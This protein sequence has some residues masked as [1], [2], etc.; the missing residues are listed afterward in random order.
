MSLRMGLAT[1]SGSATADLSP[2]PAAVSPQSIARNVLWSFSGNVLLAFCQWAIVVVLARLGTPHTVGVFALALAVA[3]PVILLASLSL[4]TYQVTDTGCDYA[5]SEYITIRV[6]AMAL[7][8]MAIGGIAFAVYGVDVAWVIVLVGVAKALDAVSDICQGALQQAERLDLMARSMILSGVLSLAGLTAG[9]LATGRLHWGVMGM[10]AASALTLG[11]YNLPQAWS[12]VRQR[13]SASLGKSSAWRPR[14]LTWLAWSALPLTLAHTLTALNANVPRYYIE[15]YL[16]EAELGVFA[17][18]SYCVM[19]GQ[20]VLSAVAQTLL[21]RLSAL[22]AAGDFS[23]YRRLLSKSLLAVTVGGAALVVAAAVFG[24]PVLRVIYGAAY[25]T[26]MDVFLWLTLG[27][28]ISFPVWLVDAAISSA[29]RFRVQFPI[30]AVSLASSAVACG[31]WI[32]RYGLVGAAW[33][34]CLA[35]SMMLVLK[36]LVLIQVLRADESR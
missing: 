26:R 2:G 7:A 23:G 21:P 11:S 35:L 12:I 22:R 18:L 31:M 36:T 28:A 8:I 10:I 4:R 33:S 29:R 34:I 14:A 30:M 9:I 19:A 5:F 6:I 3:T 20:T 25:A 1:S 32:P 24:E 27:M 13:S 17:A 15:E 16:R